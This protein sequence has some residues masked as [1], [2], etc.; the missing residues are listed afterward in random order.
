MKTKC[1]QVVSLPVTIVAVAA[2]AP[3][4]VAEPTR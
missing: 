2:L 4:K 3:A 1:V